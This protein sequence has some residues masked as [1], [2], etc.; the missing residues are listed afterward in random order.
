MNNSFKQ[1]YLKYKD[2]YLKLKIQIAG[3]PTDTSNPNKTTIKD[4]SEDN[5]TKIKSDYLD[6]KEVI[7]SMSSNKES[8]KQFNWKNN[9]LINTTNININKNNSLCEQLENKAD[10]NTYINKCRLIDL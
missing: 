10:C 1:K 8:V 7:K 9:N 2:K 5:I 3:E 6:C 4:L